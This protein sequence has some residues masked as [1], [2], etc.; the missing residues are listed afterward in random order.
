MAAS[1][2]AAPASGEAMRLDG[3]PGIDWAEAELGIFEEGS[4]GCAEVSVSRVRGKKGEKGRWR[5]PGGSR[6]WRLGGDSSEGMVWGG[7]TWG[8][9]FFKCAPSGEL[10]GVGADFGGE[11][12]WDARA[13]FDACTVEAST[14]DRETGRAGTAETDAVGA[15]AVEADAIDRQGCSAAGEGGFDPAGDGLVMGGEVSPYR[16]VSRDQFAS[17][18][19]WG[20]ATGSW[21]RLVVVVP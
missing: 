5:C 7:R 17:S 4:S 11:A 21:N 19:A 3:R 9:L 10:E 1:L 20:L 14:V 8:D 12:G 15:G 16:Q 13:A 18:V 6:R 2:A